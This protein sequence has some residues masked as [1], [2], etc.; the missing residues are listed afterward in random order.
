MQLS[1][2]WNPLVHNAT[3]YRNKRE[4]NIK[5]LPGLVDDVDGSGEKLCSDG[6]SAKTN[7]SNLMLLGLTMRFSSNSML[8]SKAVT[9]GDGVNTN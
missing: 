3:D 2:A 6:L 5:I 8:S 7:P 9:S 4:I 1:A